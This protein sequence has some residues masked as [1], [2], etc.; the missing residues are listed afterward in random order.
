MSKHENMSEKLSPTEAVIEILQEIR[1]RDPEA[2]AELVSWRTN[3]NE[4]LALYPGISTR[5]QKNKHQLGLVGVLNG[6]LLALGE[7]KIASII[8]DEE[9]LGFVALPA[10]DQDSDAGMRDS[11]ILPASRAIAVG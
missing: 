11:E 3:V 5:A 6:V 2:F 10:P 8:E 7:P 1:R 9:I 4:K